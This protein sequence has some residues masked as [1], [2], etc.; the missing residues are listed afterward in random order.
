MKP[1]RTTRSPPKAFPTPDHTLYHS[2]HLSLIHNIY[3]TYT[4]SLINILKKKE[5]TRYQSANKTKKIGI[6]SFFVFKRQE[7]S[8]TFFMLSNLQKIAAEKDK[9]EAE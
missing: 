5:P 9:M 6:L 1:G 3:I 8:E 4:H 7:E 2:V